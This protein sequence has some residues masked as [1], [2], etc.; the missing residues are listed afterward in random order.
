MKNLKQWLM[1]LMASFMLVGVAEGCSNAGTETED[2]ETEDN[3]T[4]ENE[5]ETE[6]TEDDPQT[7]ENGK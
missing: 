1:V 2:T 3:Q 4:D 7:E 6:G 5:T